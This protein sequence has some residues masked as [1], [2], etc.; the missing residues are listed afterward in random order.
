MSF[1][2]RENLSVKERTLFFLSW[3]GEKKFFFSPKKKIN[4]P[5][6]G[7]L[8]AASRERYFGV[9]CR[10]RASFS[11]FSSR[12]FGRP[13]TKF[14]RYSRRHL[15]WRGSFLFCLCEKKRK[16][17]IFFAIFPRE[18]SEWV[19]YYAHVKEDTS[20]KIL[21]QYLHFFS[22]NRSILVVFS[23]NLRGQFF[24]AVSFTGPRS[25]N[26]RARRALNPFFDHLIGRI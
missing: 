16:F 13:H 15:A 12:F 14:K 8:E 5:R 4:R 19:S 1:F 9:L 3:F 25:F 6:T 20:K 21:G 17:S 11:A 18:R 22:K 24:R 23:S 2:K 7:E 10:V 26:L